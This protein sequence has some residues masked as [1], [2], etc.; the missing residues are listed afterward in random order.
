MQIFTLPDN[1]VVGPFDSIE[2]LPDGN[3]MAGGGIIPA[4][5]IVG[6]IISDVPDN[7][8]NPQ[9]QAIIDAQLKAEQTAKDTKASALAKLSALGLTADEVKALIG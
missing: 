9:Q 1:S 3:Y 4:D 2:A 7:Y 8:L 6:G 5:Q